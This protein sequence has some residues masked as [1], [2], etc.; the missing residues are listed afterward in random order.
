MLGNKYLVILDE[1]TGAGPITRRVSLVDFATMTEV[2]ILS[3]LSSSTVSPP[4][5]NQSA[6]TG[7]VFLAYGSDGT[8]LSSVG[9]YRSDNG[10]VLC[11][12]GFTIIP[13]GQTIGE[14]TST[15]LII[16]YSTGA[17]SHQKA[18]PRP[19]G[20]C[21]ITPASQT[22]PNVFVGGC[23]FTP[24][25]KQF[26]IK[27]TG[28]DCLDVNPISGA[29]PF[30]IQSTSPTLP[31]KLS[32]NE[33]V[34]VVVAF[35]PTAT[36]SWN[37]QEI[38]VT[39]SPANG[40]NKL[41]FRGTAVTATFGI[42]FSGTA[43]GFGKQPVGTSHNATLT[44]TNSGHK[45]MIVSSAGITA[46]GF[47]VAPFSN[48]LDCGASI[49]VAIQFVPPTEGPHN[50]SFSVSHSAP[51]NPTTIHLTGEGC[52]G[53]AEIVVPPI[54]PIDFGQVQQ[55]FR[56]V[57]FFTVR[58][59]GDAPLSFQG[60]ITGPNAALFGL[61]D[62]NGS[63]VNPPQTRVFTVNPVSPCGNLASGSGETIVAVAFAGNTAPGVV[64]ATL[65]LSGHNATNFAP[66]MTWAFPLVAEITPP[67]A[68]D[69]GL[70]IDRSHSMNQTLGTRVKMD[71]AIS[72]S[73]LFVELLRAD[74][75]DR[76]AVVRF[77]NDR[78][79]VVPM[80]LVSTTSSPT[81]DQI[82]QRI[83][84]DI[85]PATGLTAIAGGAMMA[86]HEV[87]KPHPNNPPMLNRALVVLTDGIENTAFEEPPGTWLSI[88]GGTMYLP[89]ATVVTDTVETNAATWPPNIPIY[90]IGVGKAGEVDPGQLNALTGDPQRVMY[91]DQDLTGT[92]YFQLEKYYTQIFMNVV[93][94]QIVLDP[95]YWIA[96]SDTHEI[97]FEVLPGDV[98]A[99]VVIYD[100]KGQRLPFVCVSPKGE[101]LDP[102]LVPPGFQVRSGYTSQARLVEFKMPLKEPD[103]YA[104]T[105][106]VVIRHAG[107]VCFGNPVRLEGRGFL[108]RECK[109]DVREPLLYGIA[110]AVGSD[111]RMLPFVTP[112]PV[113]VGDPILL[114]ALISEA[115]LPVTGGNVTVE[116]TTPGGATYSV[117]LLDDGAHADGAPDDGEY[118][119]VFSQTF[120]PGIYH[121]K[122]RAV[123]MSRDGKEVVREGV[124]DKPV[125]PRGGVEQPSGRHPED[126]KPQDGDRP[127]SRDDCCE[128]LLIELK[129]QRDLLEALAGRPKRPRR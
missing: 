64:N 101:V 30:S 61:P 45:P 46:D 100:F 91:V 120:A 48:N 34:D 7:S 78:N 69:V 122:F 15:Q 16:H 73:Q 12:L 68:L 127:T 35:N 4:V 29:G 36:G 20:K 124:R 90:A 54:A 9:I 5:V 52:I 103:R 108:P 88:R 24:P 23:P 72:A 110:I 50:A 97:E 38:P 13:T 27:N 129:K 47:T 33:D 26:V 1:E 57:R 41:V 18:C 62:P 49:S 70:V 74:R 2:P 113:Y 87:E 14:A 89:N 121:F 115:G 3:V 80:V 126:R 65:T 6:G 71:A 58:N 116:A 106:R 44:I 66:G 39:T 98:S 76:A 94:M 85:K 81:Q 92:L 105:W 25:T 77:N 19:L 53:N 60:A 79:V 10:A 114:T 128:K 119:R 42:T 63:V 112:A 117:P 32:P 82:R 21:T 55:D 8:Q 99:L 56:T 93:G 123:G 125:L 40:D 109:H 59:S 51:S 107:T 67:V 22:F 31:A 83:D 118:A 43:I 17:T 96:A 111:F 102:V 84:T 86:I 95:M 11:P 75:N 28:T 37:P 104:G